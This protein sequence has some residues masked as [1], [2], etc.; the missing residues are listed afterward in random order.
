MNSCL[1]VMYNNSLLSIL[2]LVSL[3]SFR[4]LLLQNQSWFKQST[5]HTTMCRS[6]TLVIPDF[7]QPQHMQFWEDF[8]PDNHQF[9]FYF[10][11]ILY[12]FHL[13]VLS[14]IVSM[15]RLCGQMEGKDVF[16][17]ESTK[18]VQKHTSSRSER[19]FKVP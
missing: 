7:S 13:F 10:C 1:K 12:Y 2:S 18:V 9:S 3:S 19:G 5:L 6:L 8:T 15:E 14:Q 16:L 11:I 17:R 4:Y